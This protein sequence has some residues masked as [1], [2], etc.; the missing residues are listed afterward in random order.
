MAA[1]HIESRRHGPQIVLVDDEDAPAVTRRRWCVAAGG[2]RSP[3]LYAV[4]NVYVGGRRAQIKMHKLITGWPETDHRNRN[5]LDNRR[6]NLRPASRSQ[7]NANRAVQRNNTSGYK[8]V[9]F[10]KRAGRWLAQIQYDRRNHHLG[11]YDDPRTAAL[12]YDAAAREQFGV[13]A[14]CNLTERTG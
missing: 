4:A 10:D 11:L 2:G 12:A 5:G 14:C 6:S 9:T 7:N 1:I 13:F 8:G 3:V